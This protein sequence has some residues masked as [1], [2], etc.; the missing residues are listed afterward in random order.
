MPKNTKSQAPGAAQLLAFLQ[1]NA[2]LMKAEEIADQLGF[3][4]AEGMEATRVLLDDLLAQ[5]RLLRNRRGGYGLAEKMDLIAGSVI[6]N[7]E[8]FGFL[9]PDEGVGDIYLP[10]YQMRQVLH[11]DR[12]LV[13]VVGRD[14]RDRPEGAIVSILSRRSPR[15]VGRYLEEAG[16][17][18]VAPDDARIHQNLLIPHGEEAGAKP[19]DVVVAEIVEPPSLH[20]QPV[21][22]IVRVLGEEV[23]TSLAIDMAIE[24]HDIPHEWPAAVLKE[25]A[26]I[27]DHVKPAQLRD[28]EDLRDLPLVTIDGEDARDFDDA[29]WCEPTRGG[30]WKLYVA[31]ADVASYVFPGSALDDQAQLRGTSVY[32]PNR[33]VPMLPESLSNGICSLK[34][35]VDRLCLAC[36]LRIDASGET[37]RARFFAG[38]MRSHARLTYTQVWHAIGHARVEALGSHQHLLPQLQHLHGLYQV[39]ARRRGERGAL[40]FEGQEVKFSYDEAGNID[41]VKLYERNDAHRLIEEC[42]IAANVAAAKFIRRSRVPALYRV[43]PRPPTHKYEELADF[44]ATVGMSIPPYE[45]LQPEDL[46]GVLKRAQGRPDAALIEAVVLRSQSLATYTAA[47]DGHFGLALEAYAHFTSP[48]R[49]YPDLLVHR[50]IHHAL[51]KRTPADY[52]Y[53]AARMADFGRST[54]ATERRADEAT[55][56]VAD[57]LKCA[58]MERHLGDE[59]DGVVTGVASF[60]L[61]VEILE[62]RITGM[63]H[64]TQLPNDYYH[65]DPRRRRLV[66]ERLRLSFTLADRVRIKVLRVDSLERRIDFRLAGE[67][68]T[69]AQ[70]QR[71]GAAPEHGRAQSRRRGR[72]G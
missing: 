59:F 49:R 47:C 10:P 11:G 35:E 46:M 54:S 20:R 61:F 33:V 70:Q 39:L 62:T 14:R 17:G 52:L 5:G 27:P 66:G 44:L 55:R 56:D 57:R 12:A 37:T 72:R 38:V 9:K 2:R 42:M 69:R 34:P 36:E 19:G 16:F 58:Y 31:I 26:R 60:G 15:I 22:K 64:V 25:A 41:A 3:K 1:A 21:A 68:E 50:A 4:T 71:P 8:G 45:D 32:F 65:Y 67:H 30:G 53:T 24:S 7:G 51:G 48:I 63:V 18:V 23:G 43:H 13:S 29:V 6:A 40:D 28:R